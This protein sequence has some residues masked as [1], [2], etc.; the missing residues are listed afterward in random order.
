MVKVSVVIPTYKRSEDICRAVDSVLSQT[1]D[2]FEVIVVDDNGVG[3]E[4]GQKTARVMSRYDGD[5]RVKYL[6]HDVNKNGSAARNTGIRAA[7][8]KYIAFLDDDDIYLPDRL[9]KMYEKLEGLDETWGACYSGYVKNRANKAKQYSA[10]KAEGDLFLQALMRSLYIGSGS[11][12]F[13]RRSVVESTGFF[14]ESFK[15]NQDLEYLIRVLENYKMAYVDEVLLETF[16]DIRPNSVSYAQSLEREA[17]FRK[18]FDPYLARLNKKERREVLIMYA[19][20]EA[21]NALARKKIF[22]ALKIIIKERVPLSVIFKY[23]KYAKNRKK[24]GTSYGFV[25]KL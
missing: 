25:V 12:L 19:I 21:R 16:F 3:T 22:H 11:N 7:S 20:D 9:L 14:N 5:E 8:G 17:L 10:E 6:Q 1:I 15:R 23:I 2:S 13:F 24:T 18:N 4:D